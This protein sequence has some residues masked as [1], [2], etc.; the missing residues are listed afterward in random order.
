MTKVLVCQKCGMIDF[1]LSKDHRT[2]KCLHCGQKYKIESTQS[3]VPKSIK[4]EE[5]INE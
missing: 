1:Q 5:K 3:N 4:P 2:M